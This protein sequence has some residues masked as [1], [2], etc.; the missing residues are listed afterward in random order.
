VPGLP[1]KA[2]LVS[3]LDRD[4]VIR[5]VGKEFASHIES[6][7]VP[8]YTLTSLFEQRGITR[9]DLLQIDAEGYDLSVLKSLN[10]ETV[11]PV[12]VNFE[13]ALLGADERHEAWQFLVKRKYRLFIRQPDTMACCLTLC[14][15]E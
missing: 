12:L 13:H 2:P 3:S 4:Q 1:S 11:R 10:F 14:G 8:C 7:E 9:V 5:N 6:I 15:A